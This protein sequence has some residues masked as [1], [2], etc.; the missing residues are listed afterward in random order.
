MR[1]VESYVDKIWDKTK[2]MFD[3][4]KELKD[5]LK[6]G[7]RRRRLAQLEEDVEIPEHLPSEWHDYYVT[8]SKRHFGTAIVGDSILK[9]VEILI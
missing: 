9:S 3:P 6:H 7:R 8:L 1:C 5:L 2:K 4:F